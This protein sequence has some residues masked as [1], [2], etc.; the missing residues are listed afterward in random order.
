MASKSLPGESWPE[1]GVKEEGVIDNGCEMGGCEAKTDGFIR[2]TSLQIYLI[3]YPI[4]S[5]W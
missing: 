2:L 4:I 5:P 3:D 1:E